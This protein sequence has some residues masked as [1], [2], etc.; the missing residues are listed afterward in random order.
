VALQSYATSALNVESDR[1]WDVTHLPEGCATMENVSAVTVI[2]GLALK[3]MQP[4][5]EETG[6]EE[7]I[8]DPGASRFPRT[9]A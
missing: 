6:I 5:K 3:T 7:K 9:R 8:S 4:A 1:G 2:N